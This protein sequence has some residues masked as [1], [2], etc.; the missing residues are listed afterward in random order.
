MKLCEHCHAALSSK[1]P[2]SARFCNCSCSNAW[3]HANGVRRTYVNDKKTYE[4]WVLKL[5]EEGAKAR[6]EEYRQT[7]SVATSGENNGMFG[8]THSEEV[9][10]ATRARQLGFSFEE[11]LGI[12]QAAITKANMRICN[13]GDRNP[14][15][16]KVYD[17][18]GRSPYQ[19]YFRDIHF[20]SLWELSFL[21][22]K[23]KVHA[24]VVGEPFFVRYRHE[25]RNRTYRPDFLIDQTVFEVKPKIFVEHPSNLPKFVAIREHCARENLE[26][27]I[28]TEDDLQILTPTQA[29]ALDVK[30]SK[31]AEEKLR[32]HVR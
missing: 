29:L 26:F 19:G 27:S 25:D 13:A 21:V 7:L 6:L 4:W 9:R 8:K 28:V 10:Q 15:Y 20:R 24:C 14:A 5:G 30:W 23:L 18:A 22:E 17:G 16:G 32:K 1:K 3:Q 12:E 2:K 31:N 11:R